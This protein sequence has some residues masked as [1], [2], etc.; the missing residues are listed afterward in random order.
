MTIRDLATSEFSRRLAEKIGEATHQLWF[1]E[2]TRLQWCPPT[3]TVGVANRHFVDWLSERYGKVLSDL[4]KELAGEEATVVIRI[5]QEL[6]RRMRNRLGE[7]PGN[8]ELPDRSKAKSTPPTATCI[9]TILVGQNRTKTQ[10]K[11]SKRLKTLTSFFPGNINRQALTA[12]NAVGQG[13]ISSG[14]VLFVGPH[15]VGKTHLLEGIAQ[16]A[17]EGNQSSKAILFSAEDFLQKFLSNLRSNSTGQWRRWVRSHTLFLLDDLHRLAGKRSTQEELLHHLDHLHREGGVF[18]TSMTDWGKCRNGLIPE[19]ADRLASG[20]H[21]RL[22]IPDALSKGAIFQQSLDSMDRILTAPEVVDWIG[23]NLFGSAREIQGAAQTLWL[24]A[25]TR[26]IPIDLPLAREVLGHLTQTAYS[27]KTLEQIEEGL[28][29]IL[30]VSGEELRRK[31][32]DKRLVLPRFLAAYL[33]R[34]FTTASATEI[35]EFLGGRSHSTILDGDKKVK[36]WLEAKSALLDRPPGLELLVERLENHLQGSQS[37][38]TN[39]PGE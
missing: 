26:C 27:P 8:Q 35:G 37:G 28:Q 32:R 4:A 38:V 25:K 34:K 29:L 33:A 20:V 1:G 39:P 30:G 6:F 31:S 12:A 19:L 9:P 14:S 17:R 10:Q 13:W 15:G 36:I 24:A 5:D 7:Q 23:N 18:V 21:S 3:L 2:Q 16:A 22:S 11:S